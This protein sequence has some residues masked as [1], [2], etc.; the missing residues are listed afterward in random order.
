MDI[1]FKIAK[2]L[3]LLTWNVMK[4]LAIIINAASKSKTREIP[5]CTPMEAYIRREEGT[6]S[7]DDFYNATH[8]ND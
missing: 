8:Q 2:G 3:L 6:I 1:A 5:V 7:F 4:V